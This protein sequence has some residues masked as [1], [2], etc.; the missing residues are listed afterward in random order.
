MHF[1]DDDSAV[2]TDDSFWDAAHQICVDAADEVGDATNSMYDKIAEVG[3]PEEVADKVGDVVG[4]F[5]E[6]H[7]PD[8]CDLPENI[9]D[10]FDDSSHSE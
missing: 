9:S 2:N 10:S 7:W 1:F 5:V 3:L 4:G 6:D 8:V